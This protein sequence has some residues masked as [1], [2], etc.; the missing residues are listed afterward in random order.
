MTKRISIALATVAFMA[1][2]VPAAAFGNFAIHGNYVNDTD[3]CAGCHRAHTAASTLTWSQS[4]GDQRSAL[5]MSAATT[6]EQFCLTC[7]DS[8]GQSADT[9]VTDG[10]Y[11]GTLYGDQFAVLNGGG[12]ESFDATPVT[13]THVSNGAPWGAFGGGY[14]GQGVVGA[15]G[16]PTALNGEGKSNDIN[17]DCATCHDPHGSANYRILKAQVNGNY[18]GGY[19]PSGDPENPTPD[20]WVSSVEVGWPNNGFVLHEQPGPAYQPNYTTPMYAKGYDMA[21]GVENPSKG[22]SGWCSGCHSTYLGNPD[23]TFTPA[24][25]SV[26]QALATTYNA[27][28]GLGYKLRH[29]HPMNVELSTYD[30]PDKA[31]MIITA[32][33]LPLANDLSEKG[34]PSNTDSDW[35]E[36][37]TCHRAHGTIAS[38][39]GTYSSGTDP[40]LP[41]FPAN[42]VSALLRRDNRGVCEACHNK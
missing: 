35:I 19:Q 18:V 21:T 1:L 40:E 17:M 12:F 20:G 39:E 27:G 22:M 37:L 38:M 2:L 5:L 4:D 8:Q 11:Y 31:S 10:L 28:D 42:E 15:T 36:C 14:A 34:A 7:H 26:Y 25:G 3:A 23:Q 6:M 30:G 29:K 24:V 32:L 16:N 41:A 33:P 9:N 13:S